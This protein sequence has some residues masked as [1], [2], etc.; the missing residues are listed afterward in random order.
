[1]N[2]DFLKAELE[3]EAAATRRMF[4]RLPEELFAW[5]PHEKS[6]PLGVLAVHIVTMVEWIFFALSSSELDYAVAA[7]VSLKPKTNAQLLDYFDEKV[8]WA[9]EAL[10]SA[11]DEDLLKPWTV[12]K[13]DR[14]FFVK[15]RAEVIRR[16]C[17]N[18]IIHHRGQLSVYMRLN[19]LV[20]PG[21]YGPTADA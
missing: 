3:H 7:P 13:G 4:E 17:L 8:K 5:R 18:H 9:V 19:N 16:D 11:S 20:L 6:M 14:I 2:I 1:M 21:V 10:K 15:P 12:R